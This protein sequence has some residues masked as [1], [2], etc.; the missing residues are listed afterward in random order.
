[1]VRKSESENN[2]QPGIGLRRF[3]S[4]SLFLLGNFVHF[5]KVKLSH[6]PVDDR[7]WFIKFAVR[8]FYGQRSVPRELVSAGREFG[9]ILT[10]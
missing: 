3:L 7:F 10:F 6:R 4:W 1:M 8:K 9:Q 5:I 2:R